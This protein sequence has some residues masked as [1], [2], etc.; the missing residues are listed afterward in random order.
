MK[1]SIL[2]FLIIVLAPFANATGLD[3]LLNGVTTPVKVDTATPANSKP[4][5]FMYLNPSGV[6]AELGTEAT[7]QTINTSVL[8]VDTKLQGIDFATEATLSAINTK[9]A[10]EATL[11]NLNSKDFATSAKQDTGNASLASIDGKTPAL[12]G[13]KVPVDVTFPAAQSVTQGTTPWVVDGSAVTQPVSAASLP[14]P[15]GAATET[16]LS[17]LNSKVSQNFGAETSAVRTAAQIGNASGSA[18][19]G[20]GTASA[21][22]LRVVLPTDQSPIATKTPVN[23]QAS[24]VTITNVTT[25]AQSVSV[26]TGAVGFKIYALDTNT[27]NL[28]VVLGGTATASTG[29]QLQPGRSEDFNVATAISV[30]AESGTGQGVVV[31]WIIP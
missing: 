28:R 22:T 9:V 11:A 19:F 1:N 26:P 29:I 25:T 3:Y 21:Q 16:T 23:T 4:Y 13:G 30:I 24:T 5:P 10:T 14:L 6:R 17:S 7:L 18:D 15:T 27:A 31:I 12:V 2:I 8:G 20:S